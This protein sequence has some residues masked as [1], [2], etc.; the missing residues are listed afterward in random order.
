M[1][2]KLILSMRCD[3]VAQALATG[4][5]GPELKT[6][7]VR[8]FPKPLYTQQ[9][10]SA[11]CTSELGKENTVRKRSGTPH[12]TPLL[13]QAS[14]LTLTSL[15]GCWLRKKPFS[16]GGPRPRPRSPYPSLCYVMLRT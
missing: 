11:W 3:C 12:F 16:R 15:H 2:L 4:N 14:L 7:C 10:M 1:T 8:D 5:E 13:V 6:T 9:A